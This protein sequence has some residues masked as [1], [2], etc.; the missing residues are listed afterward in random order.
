[1]LKDIDT[2]NYNI[3]GS[4]DKDHIIYANKIQDY[5]KIKTILSTANARFYTYTP[6]QEQKKNLVSKGIIKEYDQSDI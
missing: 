5:N 3:K 2:K 6:K 1:M 4:R